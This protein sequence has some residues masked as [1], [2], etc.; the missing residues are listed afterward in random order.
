MLKRI[1]LFRRWARKEKMRKL[2]VLGFAFGAAALTTTAIFGCGDKLTLLV[3]SARL[4]QIYSRAHPASV[5]AYVRQNSPASAVVREL[6]LRH[7][8]KQ[9]GYRFY[10][11]ENTAKLDSALTTGRFDLVLAD[12]SDAE[13]LEEQVRS[14][15][16][17]PLM[18]P[19][20][21]KSNK[22]EAAAAE[23][24]FHRVL[25]APSNGDTYLA[26]LDDAME[27]RLKGAAKRR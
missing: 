1:S 12:V 14:A 5:L 13:S 18:L 17:M 7:D 20:V 26:A 25:K 24:R 21:Y 19:I 11:V 22:P 3:G 27:L 16:S 15:P 8:L 6:E 9:A 10:S 4:R 23:K 2:F